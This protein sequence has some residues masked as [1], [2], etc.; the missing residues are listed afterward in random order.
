[1]HA[2]AFVLPD[3]RADVL[4][5]GMQWFILIPGSNHTGSHRPIDA[6]SK[7]FLHQEKISDLEHELS[8]LVQS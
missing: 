1:M 4:I 2:V 3:E 6:H 7:P 5:A 8:T